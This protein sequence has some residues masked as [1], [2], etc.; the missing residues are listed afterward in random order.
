MV[1]LL[2]LSV[3]TPLTTAHC[4]STPIHLSSPPLTPPD[5]FSTLSLN[6]G[7]LSTPWQYI[8]NL[9]PSW[10]YCPTCASVGKYNPY[11]D[12]YDANIRCGRGAATAGEG[13]QTLDLTAGD[14]VRFYSTYTGQDG[15]EGLKAMEHWG[16]GQAY[17]SK[18]GEGEG[19]LE[20][21]EGEGGWFK[22]GSLGAK[23]D[24]EW[25]LDRAEYVSAGGQ[26]EHC[27]EG[28]N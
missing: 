28:K 27:G 5:V 17:L 26:V 23:S 2:T 21:Y 4:P 9:Q 12:V 10:A 3:L 15:V 24:G 6:R 22:I 8:R 11:Y 19:G 14:E 20:A 16:P 7:P 18:A 1:L 25:V 13:V